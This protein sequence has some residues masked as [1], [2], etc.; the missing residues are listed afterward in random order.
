MGTTSDDAA[1]PFAGR[2]VRD[3]GER[4]GFP[5][6][7]AEPIV[8]GVVWVLA[9]EKQYKLLGKN[10]LG[11]P[12]RATPSVARGQMFLRTESQLVSVGGGKG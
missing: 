10:P 3:C 5:P 7:R 6:G 2:V 8:S 12:S 1:G 9:A 11:E 4:T